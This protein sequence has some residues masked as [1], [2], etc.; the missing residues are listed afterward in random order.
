MIH[1]FQLG[2]LSPQS[3]LFLTTVIPCSEEELSEISCR[4][5]IR[6]MPERQRKDLY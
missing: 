1:G 6:Q 2:H 3:M 5:L 4:E